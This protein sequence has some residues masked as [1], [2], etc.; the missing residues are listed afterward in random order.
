MLPGR[1][2]LIRALAPETTVSTNVT[3]GGLLNSDLEAD[4][5]TYD[6]TLNKRAIIKTLHFKVIY[7]F[8]TMT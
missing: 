3:T 5:G 1:G 6:N 8:K 7:A 2:M 4:A